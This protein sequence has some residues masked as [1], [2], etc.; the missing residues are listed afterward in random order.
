M[1]K[2]IEGAAAAT[3]KVAEVVESAGNFVGRIVG[4]PADQLS[5][6]LSDQLRFWRARN[7]NRIAEM[8]DRLRS[9]RPWHPDAVRM[10]PFGISVQALEK[11]SAEEDETLQM[12]WARF[13]VNAT[14][15]NK[16]VAITKIHTDVLASLTAVDAHMIDLMWAWENPGTSPDSED[17]YELRRARREQ[18]V[19]NT[20]ITWRG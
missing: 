19:A 8:Y 6:L 9:D 15:P 5:G 3:K 7:L 13:F 17:S 10:L 20:L 2:A 18:R 11:A 14:D 4:P 1:S 16:D 12:M